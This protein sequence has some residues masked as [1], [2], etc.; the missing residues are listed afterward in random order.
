[1]SKHGPEITPYLDTFHAVL[2]FE[3][4]PVYFQTLL[5]FRYCTY[6]VTL[7]QSY[8]S[9]RKWLILLQTF[10][11][12]IYLSYFSSMGGHKN[13]LVSCSFVYCKQQEELR[14][15]YCEGVLKRFLTGSVQLY[16]LVPLLQYFQVI[17]FQHACDRVVAMCTKNWSKHTLHLYYMF[18]C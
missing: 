18:L 17:N 12:S 5:C 11:V 14:R 15:R 2:G 6:V 1:M 3:I 9:L 10:L 7:W 8:F 16:E 13:L 4:T